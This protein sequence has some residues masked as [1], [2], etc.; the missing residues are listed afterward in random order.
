MVG[1]YFYIWRMLGRSALRLFLIPARGITS[2][3]PDYP[4]GIEHAIRMKE[5][6]MK[7]P[8]KEADYRCG[9]YLH[10]AKWSFYDAEMKL[11]A[12]RVPQP[13]YKRKDTMPEFKK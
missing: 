9:E 12:F 10:K 3:A 8:C 1:I 11:T 2:V 6:G 7:T 4:T 13:S 5:R